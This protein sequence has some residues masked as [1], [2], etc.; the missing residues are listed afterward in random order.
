MFWNHMYTTEHTEDGHHILTTTCL[1]EA[2]FPTI[3][4]G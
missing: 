3:H 1:V 2:H 4:S